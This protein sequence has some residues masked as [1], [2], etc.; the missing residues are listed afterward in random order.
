MLSAVSTQVQTIQASI[1]SHSATCYL[2]GKTI[3]VDFNS[4]IFVTLN[5]AGKGYGGRQKLP[6][7]LKQLF[8]PVVMSVPDNELIAE[9]LLYS[10]GFKE[11]KI[12]SRKLVASFSLSRE[13]LSTQQHYDWGL[14]A[15]K[16]VLRGC[17]DA[18]TAN[19]ETPEAKIVVQTLMLNTLS[20]LTFADSKRFRVLLDD[21]FPDVDKSLIQFTQMEE[22]LKKAA[23]EMSMELTGTQ[24]NKIFELYEQLRQRTGVVIVGPPGSGKSTLWRVLKKAL[25]KFRT[26]NPTP[27][28]E[29]KGVDCDSDFGARNTGTRCRNPGKAFWKT[30]I[31]G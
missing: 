24:I 10:E 12:L 29:F 11:A 17:G 22:E 8:R 13:M 15:L 3:P 6:D 27:D 7:N 20:K 4:A 21:I 18:I 14:R 16:T 25:G 23:S 9:T 31:C 2:D 5:P 26:C 1:R 28:S 19:R 30:D